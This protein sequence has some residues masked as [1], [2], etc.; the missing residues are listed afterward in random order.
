MLI[1]FIVNRKNTVRRRI[2]KSYNYLYNSDLISELKNILNVDFE[3][4]VLPLFY[5]PIDYDCMELKKAMKGAGTDEDTIIEIITNRNNAVIR[6]IKER[7]PIVNSGSDLINNVIS[8][9]SKNFKNTLVAL[10]EE[11]RKENL[12]SN[13]EECERNARYLYE[14]QK[15]SVFMEI[16]TEKSQADFVAIANY[17]YQFYGKSLLDTVKNKFSGDFENGLIGIYY[18]MINP[19]EYFV[20]R[21]HDSIYG[22]GTDD[23]TLTRVIVTRYEID[24]PE[25]KEVYKH[26]YDADMIEDIKDDTSGNYRLLLVSLAEGQYARA[27]FLK[28]DIIQIIIILLWYI[29]LS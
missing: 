11:K 21:I 16:F 28:I 15:E 1:K 13:Y 8:D 12:L 29:I 23:N 4:A 25:I 17:Y 20:Q 22:W 9:T 27:S 5:D 3:N 7:Y 6:Q 24:L 10:L 14:N 18:A 2:M 26:K 19:A